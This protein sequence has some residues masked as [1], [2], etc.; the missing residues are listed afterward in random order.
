MSGYQQS[1]PRVTGSN[2]DGAKFNLP[3]D[4]EGV[5]N[6]ILIAFRREQTELIEGWISCLEDLI[7]KYPGLRYYEL[8]VLSTSYSPFRWW[9]GGGMRAGIV[10]EMARR[11][12]I[13]VYTRKRVFKSQIGILSEENIYVLL[14]DR[15]G[16]VF[17][18]L[19][20]EFAEE[21]SRQLQI[22]VSQLLD[23]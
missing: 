12:T 16:R 1:F 7:K 3:N 11:R 2:L 10:D 8:P 14:V 19:E 18:R 23:K 9:I 17:L 4:F 20:G 6:I 22:A 5:L 15:K 13:T 21:K